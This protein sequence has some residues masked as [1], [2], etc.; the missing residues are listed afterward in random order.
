MHIFTKI[1]YK[2]IFQVKQYKTVRIWDMSIV[3]KKRV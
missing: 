1:W 2:I 3:K